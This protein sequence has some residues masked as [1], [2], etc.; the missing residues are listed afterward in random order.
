MLFPAITAAYAAVLALLFAAL[1]AWVIAGRV[2][3]RVHHGD[4]GAAML[5]RRIRAHANFSEY[6]PMILG[7]VGLLEASGASRAVIHA[8]L[9]VLLVARIMHPIGMVAPEASARQF[10]FR[11]P[12]VIATIAVLIVSA[13]LLLIRL[14]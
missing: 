9:L 7:L 8:L 12:S 13:M 11:A 2:K 14:T 5:N 4:G 10:A 3:F 1:S 6:V